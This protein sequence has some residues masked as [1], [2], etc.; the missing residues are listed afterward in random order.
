[1]QL[2]LHERQYDTTSESSL[3]IRFDGETADSSTSTAG[4]R[5]NFL[6]FNR[7]WLLLLL[8]FIFY[9]KHQQCST[10]HL[11]CGTIITGFH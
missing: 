4:T 11:S 6:S 3:W 2:T 10:I 1:M 9:K 7:S 5:L 8:C